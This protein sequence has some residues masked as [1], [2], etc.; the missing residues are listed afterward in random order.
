MKN[1]LD[2]T[3]GEDKTL[4]ESLSLCHFVEEITHAWFGIKH[5]SSPSGTGD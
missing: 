2:C 3:E 4:A 1:W 5:G